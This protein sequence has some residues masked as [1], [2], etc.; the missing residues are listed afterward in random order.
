MATTFPSPEAAASAGVGNTT[1]N[2]SGLTGYHGASY[3]ATDVNWEVQR[4]NHFEVVLAGG[5]FF[6]GTTNATDN[7]NIR[8][9]VESV[10][11]PS[12]NIEITELRH[13]NEI[14]KVA[15]IHLMMGAH[16]FAK[17]Q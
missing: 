6:D 11:I 7:D 15:S 13:G 2:Q 14:V 12:V 4:T 3:F 1:R 10:K 5:I 17:M 16:L 8:L 9:A